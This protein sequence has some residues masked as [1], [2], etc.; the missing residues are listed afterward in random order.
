MRPSPWRRT[1]RAGCATGLNGGRA[2]VARTR[3]GWVSPPIPFGSARVRLVGSGGLPKGRA[4]EGLFRDRVRPRFAATLLQPPEHLDRRSVRE[5]P[6]GRTALQPFSV[7]AMAAPP[8]RPVSGQP[9]A[10]PAGGSCPRRHH[11]QDQARERGGQGKR[12]ERT[13]DCPFF[14][15]SRKYLVSM[16][17]HFSKSA[18]IPCKSS[19]RSSANP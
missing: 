18:T 9:G 10:S 17:F 12:E 8:I 3:C 7:Y 6:T 13:Q 1:D 16:S 14:R 2:S 15:L 11:K 19:S 4:P 5:K